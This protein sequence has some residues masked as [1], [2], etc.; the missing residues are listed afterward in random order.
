MSGKTALDVVVGEHLRR[1]RRRD[2]IKLR[3]VCK[4]S[5]WQMSNLCR[6]ERGE[7]KIYLKS[8]ID[9]LG[10]LGMTLREFTVEMEK[11]SNVRR[12]KEGETLSDGKQAGSKVKE[13]GTELRA[14]DRSTVPRERSGS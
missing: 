9:I 1:I 3:E 13:K 2:K 10:A 14:K 7:V 4:R 11:P 5:G 12:K 6:L 8:L